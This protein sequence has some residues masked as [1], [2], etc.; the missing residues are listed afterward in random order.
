MTGKINIRRRVQLTIEIG[1]KVT[2][3]D[4]DKKEH[5]IIKSISDEDHVFVVYHCAGEWENY[6]NYTAARTHIGNLID[7]WI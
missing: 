2:Y 7:G 6:K 4:F 1:R 3:L 5:G